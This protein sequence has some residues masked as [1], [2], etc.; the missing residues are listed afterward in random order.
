MQSQINEMAVLDLGEESQPNVL[1]SSGV[2]K[3]YQYPL[4]FL[5]EHF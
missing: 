3:V 2:D 4:S 5:V 1:D